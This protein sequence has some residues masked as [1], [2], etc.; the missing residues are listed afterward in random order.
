MNSSPINFLNPQESRTHS[1]S[2][3]SSTQPHRG[4]LNVLVNVLRKELHVV[5]KEFVGANVDADKY[6]ETDHLDWS[7]SGDV[8]YHMGI[9]HERTYSN[10]HRVHLS[11]LPN[12]SHLEGKIS[13]PIKFS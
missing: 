10:G 12:P 5:F 8:K 1:P 7:A 3:H 2:A 4:R 11:L 9:S 13:S 6:M